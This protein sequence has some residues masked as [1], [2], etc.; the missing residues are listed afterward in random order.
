MNAQDFGDFSGFS[1]IAQAF[2][3][4]TRFWRL[5]R[6]LA[7]ALAFSDCLGLLAIARVSRL[8]AVLQA[9]G[10]CTSFGD[11]FW[12]LHG[13]LVAEHV[14]RLHRYVCIRL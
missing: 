9:F 12:Q 7:T 4:C 13:L 11:F 6:L 3:E 1:L 2:G 5:L 10:D 14:A 8:L